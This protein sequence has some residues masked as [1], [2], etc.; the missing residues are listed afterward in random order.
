MNMSDLKTTQ[1]SDVMKTVI[2][3]PLQEFLVAKGVFVHSQR[4]NGEIEFVIRVRDHP[5]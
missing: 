5:V 4:F 1:N 2:L 3:I